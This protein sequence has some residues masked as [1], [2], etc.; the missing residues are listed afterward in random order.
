MGAGTSR[1]GFRAGILCL[2]VWL[3][4]DESCL[5]LSA[6]G[7]FFRHLRVGTAAKHANST[8]AGDRVYAAD[9]VPEHAWTADGA[10]RYPLSA[11]ATRALRLRSAGSC[12][13]SEQHR[14]PL[15]WTAIHHCIVLPAR[16]AA[17]LFD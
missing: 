12:S 3:H 2:Q 17:S 13:W 7:R 14:M 15:L 9:A 10:T 6:N 4:A 16:A 8:D 5:E 11:V 1:A